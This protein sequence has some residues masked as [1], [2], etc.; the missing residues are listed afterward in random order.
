[1]PG[2]SAGTEALPRAALARAPPSATS[3]NPERARHLNRIGTPRDVAEVV[4][5]LLPEE[6]SWIT[7][8]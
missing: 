1:M 2:V 5:F 4:V 7:D 6:A 3:S 8:L